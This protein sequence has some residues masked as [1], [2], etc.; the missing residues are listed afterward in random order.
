MQKQLQMP[1]MSEAV[2]MGHHAG[3]TAQLLNL[4]GEVLFKMWDAETG[5]VQ[6]E[7]QQSNIVT[8]DAGIFFARVVRGDSIRPSMLAVGTGALGPVLAPSAP[9]NEQ[10]SLNAEIFRKPFAEMVYRDASGA[11][12]PTATNILDVVTVFNAAEAV[13]PLN[14]MA[15]VA[16]LSSDSLVTNPNPNLAG[17]GGAAY[18]AT[19]DVSASDMI[20]NHIT[21]P[22]ISK[23]ASSLFSVTWRL[24]F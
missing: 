21:F 4:K 14:E 10:R 19:V 1:K 18:D 13:G 2:S 24:T 23:A 22:V 12:S 9:S 11:V 3:H 16:P 17:Q 8:L 6:L 20:L 15:L 7:R 5:E